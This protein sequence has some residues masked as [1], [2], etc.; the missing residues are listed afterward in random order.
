MKIT[1]IEK[2]TNEHWLNLFAATYE[3]NGH[4]GR[5]VF[6]SRKEKPHSGDA[7]DAV[8]IAPVLRNPGDPPRLVMIREYRVPIGGYSYALPA[9]LIEKGEPIEETIRRE[10]REETGFEVTAV[11]RVT[12]PLFSSSGLTDEAAAMAFIDV[13]GSPG[14]AQ[15]LEAGEEIEV[16]LLDHEGICRL[17]DDAS[18]RIDAKAWTVLY[19]YRQL[20]KLE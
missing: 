6:A 1:K 2:L 7:G 12:Q 20:G 14:A 9:G 19:M 10:V 3:H 5:W 13:K 11:R 16:V 8:I 4:I 15:H 18:V 17:C